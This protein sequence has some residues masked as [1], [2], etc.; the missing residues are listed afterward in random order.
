MRRSAI[1]LS[2]ILLLLLTAC[3]AYYADYPGTYEPTPPV[4][5]APILPPLVVLEARPY[6][7]YRGY[8]YHWDDDHD[9]WLYSR[10]RRGP[11]YRLPR[12]HYPERFRYKEKWH[13]GRGRAR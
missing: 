10:Y 4:V 6:Y 11:W 8:Y 7:A 5:I 9:F 3:M 2:A 13:Q 1:M 12:S